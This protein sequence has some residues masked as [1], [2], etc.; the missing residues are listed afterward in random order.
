[1]F[2]NT[3]GGDSPPPV[4]VDSLMQKDFVKERISMRDSLTLSSSSEDSGSPFVFVSQLSN[5]S[6]DLKCQ[7]CIQVLDLEAK[8]HNNCGNMFCSECLKC[9]EKCNICERDEIL[10]ENLSDISDIT[11]RQ[12]EGLLVRCSKCENYVLRGFFKN[13]M[14][15]KCSS[16]LEEVDV[17]FKKKINESES[18]CQTKA[19]V[20][21]QSI[22]QLESKLEYLS[23]Q[24]RELEGKISN[25]VLM[26]SREE[27]SQCVKLD[28]GGEIINVALSTLLNTEYE[29]TSSLASMFKEVTDFDEE[30]FID[31]DVE[32]FL[33]ILHWLR[34]GKI[35]VN[36]NIA[37]L[38]IDVATSFNMEKLKSQLES[39]DLLTESITKFGI[40][41]EKK[42]SRIKHYEL[43]N[44][45][46][47]HR[48]E[49]LE[50]KLSN[51]DL[52][53]VSL[54]D[55]D[56]RKI[57]ITD[58]D[59]S[60]M[61]LSEVNFSGC[62]LRGCTFEKANLAHANLT[63]CDLRYT[64]FT[65]ANLTG[66][67]LGGANLSGALFDNTN[68]TNT[69]LKGCD[70]TNIASESTGCVLSNA[71]MNR[72]KVNEEFLR[73]AKTL[74]GVDLSG[75]SM[76]QFNFSNM[77]LSSSNFSNTILNQSD[78][79]NTALS[80]ANFSNSS[81]AEC[82]FSRCLITGTKFINTNLRN[83]NMS[84]INPES[85]GYFISGAKLNGTTV[86]EDFNS[87]AA[88]VTKKKV[89]FRKNQ[90]NELEYLMISDGYFYGLLKNFAE[91]E[92]ASE[93]IL[94]WEKVRTISSNYTNYNALVTVEDLREIER[95]FIRNY[96]EY[97]INLS[98]DCKKKF[99]KLI[100]P[101]YSTYIQSSEE[102]GG[103]DAMS[104]NIDTILSEVSTIV[105]V[106]VLT[107]LLWPELFMNISDTFSRLQKTKQYKQ[108]EKSTGK[109]LE[110]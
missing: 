78:F 54:K 46:E 68:F 39:N 21:D 15:S 9:T 90:E 80:N 93:N 40:E 58:S 36:P 56:I 25:I 92:F 99:Y 107:D 8:T 22:K 55:L 3:I 51:I 109:S 45:I 41:I 18:T 89:A 97:E 5:I 47:Y 81:M 79:T 23:S 60:G 87:K 106:K 4:L 24:S 72:A 33:L 28:V 95:D 52:K 19:V 38:L 63:L 69:N 108:W 42:K 65:S 77:D 73:S 50:V 96:S 29:P 83:C 43:K 13:H 64:N 44:I 74:F 17:Y 2:R 110:L 94:I 59:F 100:F 48:R 85:T 20:F 27:F 26:S 67:S 71:K 31:C 7:S 34:F 62:N 66:G 35:S 84:V 101:S 76:K 16:Y 86:G 14:E 11:K 102:E 103:F 61:N 57:Q 49:N 6:N 105:T 12:I 10:G 30:H 88:Q 70:L 104:K 98:S 75:C 53:L 91:K 82:I 32:L 37:R 1:M